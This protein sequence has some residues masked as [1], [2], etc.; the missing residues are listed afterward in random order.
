[1]S[2]FDTEHA[3]LVPPKEVYLLKHEGNNI[4]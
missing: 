1:M 2:E 4:H 3:Y